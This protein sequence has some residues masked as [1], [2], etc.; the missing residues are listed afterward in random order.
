MEL[1]T[2]VVAAI[3]ALSGLSSL[4]A[5]YYAQRGDRALYRHYKKSLER[6]RQFELKD[7]TPKLEIPEDEWPLLGE[8]VRR[9]SERAY[10]RRLDELK[11]AYLTGELKEWGKQHKDELDKRQRERET[12][13]QDR[14]RGFRVAAQ[15]EAEERPDTP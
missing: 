4:L 7:E 5:L 1:A 2:L 9:E 15:A 6:E 13:L 8:L 12:V 3:A 10:G 11:L 14:L